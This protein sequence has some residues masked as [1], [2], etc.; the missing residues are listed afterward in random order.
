MDWRLFWDRDDHS[1]YVNAR[2]KQLHFAR[3]ANDLLALLPDPPLHLLDY[4]CGE[5]YEARRIAAHCGRL[6]L[7]DAAPSVQAGLKRRFAGS[8]SIQALDDADLAGLAPGSIDAILCLSVLQ[9]MSREECEALLDVW[10]RLLT[11]GGQL[12]LGDVIAPGAH[13]VTDITSL[14]GFAREGGFLVAALRGLAVTFF[15]DYRRL[16]QKIGLSTYDEST[17]MD[18]LAAHG[19]AGR[20]AP[21]NI[22]HNQARVTYIATRL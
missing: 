2:H 10:H 6:S 11:P 3:V 1:I 20:R 19:F 5:A 18:M 4:G 15:S 7:Y 8:A 17:I 14:L 21:R 22:G 9:Y 12:I 13:T 16:R